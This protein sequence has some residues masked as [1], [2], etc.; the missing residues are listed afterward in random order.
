MRRG[1]SSCRSE[2]DHHV[3]IFSATESSASSAKRARNGRPSGLSSSLAISASGSCPSAVSGFDRASDVG[4]HDAPVEFGVKLDAPA[5]VTEIQRVAGIVGRL[6][7]HPRALGRGE[8]DFHVADVEG[9]ARGKA[10]GQRVSSVLE[11]DYGPAHP[12]PGGIGPHRAAQRVRQKLMA[13]TNA[14]NGQLGSMR[15]GQPVGR[16]FRPFQPVADHGRRSGYQNRRGMIQRLDR[17]QHF[18]LVDA[19]RAVIERVVPRPAANQCSKSRPSTR[20]SGTAWPVLTMMS[21]RSFHCWY[22]GQ[23]NAGKGGNQ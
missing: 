9:R 6:S 11:L 10:A 5:P 23:G 13:V 19:N 17:R 12:P 20:A 15:T 8:H 4:L 18:A 22:P 16:R 3:R 14:Q 21:S 7:E 1:G 2:A